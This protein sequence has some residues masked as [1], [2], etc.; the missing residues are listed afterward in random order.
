MFTIW[1]VGVDWFVEYIDDSEIQIIDVR[2][3]SFG[4]EDRNV[5]QEYLNGYIFGVVFFD[6]EAFFDYIFSFSYMLSRSETFVV[7]MRE[8]GVNQ[9]KY[10]I[11]YDEGNFFLVLRVWWMLRIFGVEKVSILGGGFV[12]WQR[13]DLLLEEG[14]VELSEGE[15]NVAFNFEVVVKVIDVLL[16]SYENTA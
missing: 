12:G 14:V 7:A 11:V 13:D 6:I 5:V 1:F 3:A 8:L 15:F 16:V 2:M 9:D 4:Q 10:L